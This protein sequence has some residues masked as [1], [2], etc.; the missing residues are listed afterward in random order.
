MGRLTE[1]NSGGLEQRQV[2]LTDGLSWTVGSHEIKIALDYLRQLPINAGTLSDIYNFT[3]VPS[4]VNN[5]M[6]SVDFESNVPMH[7]DVTE[8]SLYAQDSWHA[9]PRL[10]LTYGLRWDLSM[11]NW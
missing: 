10:T 5:S 1:G 3:D 9:S 2:N 11:A 6:T 7:S 8:F 4:V